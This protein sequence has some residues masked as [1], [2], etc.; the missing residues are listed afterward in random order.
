MKA[1]ADCGAA[2]CQNVVI[3]SYILSKGQLSSRCSCRGQE[4]LVP[5]DAIISWVEIVA[6]AVDAAQQKF[7]KYAIR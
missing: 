2:C 3:C 6:E 4:A 1:A 7:F 5:T